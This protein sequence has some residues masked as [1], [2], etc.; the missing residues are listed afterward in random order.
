MAP[1]GGGRHSRDAE[2]RDLTR[3]FGAVVPLWMRVAVLVT[4]LAIAAYTVF[5][6]GRL[7]NG[8][9]GE[10]TLAHGLRYQAELATV[11]AS[12]ALE[13]PDAA[14][15]A[16]GDALDRGALHAGD[17]AAQALKA[18]GARAEGVAVV[19]SGSVEALAGKGEAG[20]VAEMA[21]AADR[22]G[23]TRWL[24]AGA[25]HLYLVR[26]V[27]GREGVRMVAVLPPLQAQSSK[28]GV[29]VLATPDGRVLAAS[30][31]SLAGA[32]VGRLGLTA[33]R[34]Q[35]AARAHAAIDIT[36]AGAKPFKAAAA[37]NA[38][39]GVVAIVAA[40]PNPGVAF[41]LFDLFDLLPLLA[42]ALVGVL[43]VVLV[44]VQAR[45]A[46]AAR[47]AF[48]DTE[49][50]F[51]TAVEAA[52]CGVWEWDLSENKV[53]VSD[54]MAAMLGW[55]SGGLIGGD[56]MLARV[57][58]EHRDR[59]LQGLRSAALYG[60]F[61]VS[62][63]APGPDG[64]RGAWIDARGQAL[65]DR[66]GDFNRIVGVALDV[67]DERLTQA[68]AQAAERRLKDAIESVSEAFALW[69]RRDR[70]LMSNQNFRLWFNIDARALKPG[71]DKAAVMKI[72]RLAVAQEVAAT[73]GAAGVREA[74]L[75]DGRWLQISERRT[76][77]GGLVMTAADIT[78]IKRQEA[79]RAKNEAELHR[80]VARLEESQSE[81]AVLARKY[82][83]EKTRA[84][85]ANRAKSEFLANMSHELRTPLNAI[86]GFSE[87][88]VSE[89]Y[90]PVGDRRYKEYAQ[91]ILSSGQHL[92]ALINDILDM[93]KIEAGKLN[94]KF[95]PISIEEVAED[96]LRLMRDRAEKAGLTLASEVPELPEVEADYRAVKQILLNLISNAVK[97]TP[98][99]GR[100]T[101]RARTSGGDMQLQVRDTGI[102]ISAEDLKRLAQPFE[103]VET[104][105][106]KTQQG[107]GLGLALTKSLIEMHGGRL[108]LASEQ[109]LG[110]TVTVTLPLRH[111]EDA[112]RR[113]A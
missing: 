22:A 54:F 102:G 107:S 24:G 108:D 109:G 4:A 28:N 94:L 73:D 110:T 18:S 20:P 39:A 104:Q 60:A 93:A 56:E 65:A 106:S 36:P 111:G 14:L 84:E 77:D 53:Y 5:F 10:A 13:A 37:S 67:T 61:D 26:R 30:D 86:N 46:D 32:T 27:P 92:L 82:E 50:R 35:A 64:G 17:A 21:R 69:D 105:H 12:A 58:P 42:P 52:R 7:K 113:A 97:F 89:L 33:Q 44:W 70:L 48:V 34:I 15:I 96:V 2:T 6:A 16:A 87:I 99:G 75:Q 101:V 76:A 91:D 112:G 85:A 29:T 51:R 8:G 25:S 90:G 98:S 68:R 43:L 11:R 74:E 23:A 71:S 57:A 81:L 59:V 83:I 95:E 47:Q 79:A 45:R 103:Q 40:P 31:A 63:R 38:E 78:A 19:A 3:R 41:G 1:E 72:A 49:R 9:E 55:P 62:F 100:V 88:M 80:I 66:A